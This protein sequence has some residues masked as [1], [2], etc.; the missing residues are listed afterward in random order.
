[1]SR[2]KTCADNLQNG[3]RFKPGT[4]MARICSDIEL[5]TPPNMEHTHAIPKK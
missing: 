1:M 2:A 4:E 3:F 5:I